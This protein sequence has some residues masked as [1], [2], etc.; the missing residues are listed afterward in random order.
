MKACGND[1]AGRTKCHLSCCF[2]CCCPLCLTLLFSGPISGPGPLR[3]ALRSASFRSRDGCRRQGAIQAQPEI[4]FTYCEGGR[5]R[6]A[7]RWA[8][9]ARSSPSKLDECL[10]V[11]LG[12]IFFLSASEIPDVCD[13]IRGV[14][15]GARGFFSCPSVWPNFQ[16]P[17]I[18][19]E[20]L[21]FEMGGRTKGVTLV[22]STAARARALKVTRDYC[23]DFISW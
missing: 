22:R 19:G 8:I 14:H 6:G 3:S 5:G 23:V 15:D 16:F 20:K 18:L 12:R 2:C 9:V 7:A 10:N 11:G 13:W 21:I 4:D 17:S 1:Q